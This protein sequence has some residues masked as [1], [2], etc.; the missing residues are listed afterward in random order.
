MNARITHLRFGATSPSSDEPR[1]AILAD[2]RRVTE[3]VACRPSPP[4]RAPPPRRSLECR[5]EMA[6]R[7]HGCGSDP[8][9]AGPISTAMAANFT[10]KRSSAGG[11]EVVAPA[12][13]FEMLSR[14]RR[15][16]RCH[17]PYR[18]APDVWVWRYRRRQTC[19]RLIAPVEG[20]GGIQGVYLSG[21]AMR[22]SHS[23]RRWSGQPA[24][25]GCFKRRHNKEPIGRRYTNSVQSAAP[26]S[27]AGF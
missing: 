3:V 13:S 7:T 21:T 2:R 1:L 15:S 26:L 22:C 11:G 23:S 19:G 8:R 9:R 10:S 6:R 17:P 24:R 25:D 18:S 14:C 20:Q 12:P 27:R 4:G 16:E 5:R